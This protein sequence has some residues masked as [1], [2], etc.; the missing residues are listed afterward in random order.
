M[1]LIDQVRREIRKKHYKYSTEESYTSWIKRYILFHNKKHPEILG[2]TEISQ[3]LSFL[4][5]GRNVAASTQNQALNAIVFLYKHVLK[6]ELNDF[7]N[8]ERAKTPKKLPTVLTINE[9]KIVL[10]LISGYHSLISN[11][12]YGSGLRLTECVRLRIMDIDFEQNIIMVSDGKGGVDRRTMLS[13]KVKD[14]LMFHLEKVK[15]IH[16]EDLKSGF[17]AVYLPFALN[18]KYPNAAK[19]W[20]WQYVFPSEKLSRDPRSN[21]IKRHHIDKSSTRKAVKKAAL[22]GG[23]MKRVSPHVFR[24]SFATHLIESGYDIR[25]V[26][27]LLGHKDVSTTMIYTHVLMNGMVGVKSPLDSLDN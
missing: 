8:F 24:H 17:G 4:A 9:V 23:I 22:K 10:N 27:E 20:K 11:I 5:N 14:M 13:Q 12:L 2:E 3:Y 6:I 19:S 15:E 25:T 18:R 16:N 1:K 26:Q 21:T 7:G